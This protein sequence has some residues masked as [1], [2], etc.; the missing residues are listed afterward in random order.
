MN[1]PVY[2]VPRFN[3]FNTFFCISFMFINIFFLFLFLAIP[4]SMR[5]RSAAL[6]PCS[7]SPWTLTPLSTCPSWPL[8]PSS[9]CPD[10]GSAPPLRPARSQPGALSPILGFSVASA[11]GPSLRT[12]PARRQGSQAPSPCTRSLHNPSRSRLP[13][14]LFPRLKSGPRCFQDWSKLVSAK[15]QGQMGGRNSGG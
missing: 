4:R 11:E 9:S 3:N 6:S 8:P 1:P 13:S 14:L 5:D 10:S 12:P 2:F 15:R 7:P